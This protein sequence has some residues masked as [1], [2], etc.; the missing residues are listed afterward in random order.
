MPRMP[1]PLDDPDLYDAIV[2]GGLRSPGVVVRIS[3][4]DRKVGWDVKTAKGQKG[5][6]TT[7]KDIPP[8]EVEVEIFLADRGEF[9]AWDE[10]KA[11]I[12]S[13]VAGPTPKALDVYH[14]DLAEQEITSVVKAGTV[15]TK[16]DGKGGQTKIFRLQEYSPPKPKTG[17]VSGA[18]TNGKREREAV[19]PNAAA[20][21]E[22]AKLTAEYAAT[23]W[24]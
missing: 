21:A 14:P 5:A 7:L 19:D 20:K 16:H 4:H 17:T 18:S 24:G 10:F 1:N 15:G 13:T 3:G 9:A 22:L 23:P 8:A 2:L 12:D 11:M 6:A